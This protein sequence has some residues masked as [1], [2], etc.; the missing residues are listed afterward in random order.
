MTQQRN[1]LFREAYQWFAVLADD[2]ATER[3][4]ADF[5]RWLATGPEH[6]AAWTHA[7]QLWDRFGPVETALAEQRGRR[8]GRRAVLGSALLLATAG[9]ASYLLLRGPTADYQTRPGERLAADL[10]DGS[11]VELS[12]DTAIAFDFSD[13]ARHVTLLRGEAYFTAAA[14]P[15]RPFVVLADHARVRALGTQFDIRLDDNAV[16]VAVLEHSVEL[17]SP[18]GAVV[19]ID[20]GMQGGLSHGA[21][22]QTTPADPLSV[23]S[24]RQGRLVYHDVPL[25]RVLTDLRRQTGDTIVPTDASIGDE[26]VSGAFALD[27]IDTALDTISTS[28]QLEQF[29]VGSFVLLLRK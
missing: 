5:E 4:R 18:G 17:T 13:T 29:R 20:E 11:R 6:Q 26:A 19:T 21:L 15:R 3:D 12:G 1:P 14:D 22:I 8:F 27:R 9:I 10:P 23:A 7:Q 16:A 28:L 2:E 25:R 24:W